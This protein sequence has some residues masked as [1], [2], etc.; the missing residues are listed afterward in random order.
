[1]LTKLD[2]MLVSISPEKTIVETYNRANEAINTF[3]TNT[4]QIAKWDQFKYRMAKFLGHIDFCVLRLRR[5]VDVSWEY[6]WGHCITVLH[7]IYGPSGEKTAFEMARTGNEGG[8]YSVLK[9]MAMNRAEEYIQNEISAKVI[10]YLDTLSADEQLDACSEYVA[11]Y[12]HL[13]PSEITEGN[14]LRMRANF[15][16]V[17]E[18]HPRLLLKFQGVGR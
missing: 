12:G 10:A 5:P 2:R 6:Y 7:R 13:L 3:H 14:A 8:L 16:K 11:K 17:L 1:M 4:A 18:K 9:A 15:R